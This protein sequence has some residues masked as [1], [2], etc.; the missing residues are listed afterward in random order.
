MTIP[1]RLAQIAR[2]IVDAN[3]YRAWTQSVVEEIAAAVTLQYM[4]E[5]TERVCERCGRKHGPCEGNYLIYRF[6]YERREGRT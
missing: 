6:E 5:Q 3:E 2:E 1:A 4:K